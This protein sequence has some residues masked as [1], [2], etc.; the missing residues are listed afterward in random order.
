MKFRYRLLGAAKP[1]TRR[2]NP[3]HIACVEN[4]WYVIGHDWVREAM[5]TFALSR[6]KKVELLAD[7]FQRPQDWRIEDYLKGS[8]GIFKSTD[9]FEV[10]VHFDKWAGQ[11]VGER[12]WHAS[13]ELVDLPGGGVRLRLRLNNIEEVERWVLSWG[14]HATVIRP[15]ML[16]NRVARIAAELAA[17]YREQPEG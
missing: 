12:R 9:D 7:V 3:Y 8:L 5:R 4:R 15:K 17:R 13:Q 1:Q 6:I 16:A 10:V 2:L 14:M 11:L